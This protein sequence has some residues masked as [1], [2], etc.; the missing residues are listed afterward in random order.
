MGAWLTKP[1]TTTLRSWADVG[2][3]AQYAA[4]EVQSFLSHF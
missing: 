4:P 3:G 1:V 2:Y